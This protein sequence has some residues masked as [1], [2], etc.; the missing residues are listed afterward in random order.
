MR[1]ERPI[2]GVG[3]RPEDALGLSALVD[4]FSDTSPTNTEIKPLKSF[5]SGRQFVNSLPQYYQKIRFLSYFPP[6]VC[7]IVNQI[8]YFSDGTTVLLDD[9]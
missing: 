1:S 6:L 5:T 3:I 4:T 8:S 7:T 9:S 2:R